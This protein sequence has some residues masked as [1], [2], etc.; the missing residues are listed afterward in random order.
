MP[1]EEAAERKLIGPPPRA[2][3]PPRAERCEVCL[4]VVGV[5]AEFSRMSSPSSEKSASSG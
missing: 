1:G 4:L 5:S 2:L 3:R